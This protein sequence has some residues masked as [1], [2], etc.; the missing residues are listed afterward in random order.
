LYPEEGDSER[1]V[2]G[3][4]GV[5]RLLQGMGRGLEGVYV[6]KHTETSAET[7]L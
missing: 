5:L 3:V 1:Q 2:V 6:I 4:W 7:L